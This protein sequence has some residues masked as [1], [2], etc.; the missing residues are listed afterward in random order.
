[1]LLIRPFARWT[2][3]HRVQLP[4]RGLTVTRAIRVLVA[5]DIRLYRDG[6]A[7]HLSANIRYAVVGTAADRDTARE[8]AQSAAPDVAIVDMAMADGLA[9]VRD[10]S[11]V[12]PNT[13][14]VALTVPEVERAVIACVEAGISG[15]VTRE[16]SLEDLVAVVE[17]AARGE[18]M[19]SPKMVATMLRRVCALAADRSAEAA[20][21]ELTLREVEIADLIKQGL[22][23]KQIAA[24]LTIELATVKNHVHNILEKLHVHR[25][26]EVVAI[27][28]RRAR[29]A[30]FRLE[31]A[32]EAHWI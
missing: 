5:G 32:D 25:R 28:S 30:L 11:R 13:R 9:V 6:V 12:A 10:I 19:M 22:S 15:Y 1:M 17:S 20:R 18:A 27:V 23:N 7:A 31:E 29:P 14:V 3:S 26:A 2:Q 24:R 8:L 21:A 4:G 16:G